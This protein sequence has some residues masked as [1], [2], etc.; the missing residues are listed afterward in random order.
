MR[1]DVREATIGDSKLKKT[2]YRA[3]LSF[4]LAAV[5]AGCSST[6]Q[7]PTSPS[8]ATGNTVAATASDGSTLKVTSPAIIAPIDGVTVDTQTP[9]L[10]WANSTGHYGSVGLAYT[11]EVSSPAAVVY[12]RTVGESPN[13]GSHKVELGLTRGT[14]YSW[15]VRAELG[16][17]VGPWSIWADFKPAAPVVVAPTP[18]AG[19]PSPSGFR[20]PDPPSGQ[21]LP[22]PNMAGVVSQVAAANG[23]DLRHSCQPE[24]GTWNFMDKL[25]DT[26]QAI[27]LR[28][29][30]NGKRGNS[31]DPSLDIVDYHYGAGPS[32]GS[33]QVYIM[34]T[35]GGHCGANPT[36]IWVNQTDITINSGTIGRFITRR[37]GRR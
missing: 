29:G 3:G 14:I 36:P 6:P 21:R 31:N 10:H 7:N 23:A 18:T 25:V 5:V 33:T 28:W 12:T 4:V 35:I 34:D 24:G 30:Y 32:E 16:T 11:I 26:L 13:T 22:L 2:F 1:K 27:D 37:P 9:T 8:A 15:R 19:G 17:L 20:T